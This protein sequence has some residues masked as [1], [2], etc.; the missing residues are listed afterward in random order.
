MEEPQVNPRNVGEYIV[1]Y[2]SGRREAIRLVENV[3]ITDV[4]S[5]EGLRLNSWTFTKFP[6][7][8]LESVPGWRG[9]SEIG[10]P[11]NL[12]V[13]IW[14]NPYPED[15]I[16]GIRFRASDKPDNIQLALLGL[17]LLQ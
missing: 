2:Q 16:T 3:N 14:Q 4:R 9:A 6:D 10:L 8:L 13:L 7:E 12:Q 11:L 15:K 5:S 1:E 17:T